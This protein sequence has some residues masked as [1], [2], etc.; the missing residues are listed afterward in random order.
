MKA[1]IMLVDLYVDKGD[2]LLPDEDKS[3]CKKFEH[4]KAEPWPMRRECSG[5]NHAEDP[6]SEA[7]ALLA[8]V[9]YEG[10]A[11]NYQ[12]NQRIYLL[13][14]RDHEKSKPSKA[15]SALRN[16]WHLCDEK[17]FHPKL[18]PYILHFLSREK[19]GG[20]GDESQ[21]P[22]KQ[23]LLGII[24]EKYRKNPQ[25]YFKEGIRLHMEESL[26]LKDR[27]SVF[28]A[29]ALMA[30]SDSKAKQDIS[31]WKE[32]WNNASRLLRTTGIKG[33][34]YETN[35]IAEILKIKQRFLREER[36]FRTVGENGLSENWELESIFNDIL[37]GAYKY[38]GI[39]RTN[40]GSL[41]ELT[42]SLSHLAVS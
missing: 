25:E 10:F 31:F 17:L 1:L 5:L 42:A 11:G 40:D 24:D 20:T 19:N 15:L 36:R 12:F 39:I 21:D 32:E 3:N 13:H 29:L 22:N 28:K 34:A 41:D 27:L 14:H 2:G 9:T 16:L 18:F 37:D 26:V 4:L 23:F 6:L 7:A 33:E 8:T 35:Y 38:G 30:W